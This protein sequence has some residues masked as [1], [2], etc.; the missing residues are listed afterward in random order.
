MKQTANS[1]REETENRFCFCDERPNIKYIKIYMYPDPQQV[2]KFNAQ[3]LTFY[4]C[5]HNINTPKESLPT[6]HH[7]TYH[8][9]LLFV[10]V[11]VC[12]YVC[13]GRVCMPWSADMCT[14]TFSYGECQFFF[15][16][17]LL[18]SSFIFI[19]YATHTHHSIDKV[20]YI[21]RCIAIWRLPYNIIHEQRQQQQQQQLQ[22][23]QHRR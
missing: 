10:N 4:S 2:M 6:S 13:V 8:R 9:L 23:H 22:Q 1:G 19:Y 12:T 21:N 15:F 7:I 20:Y 3:C 14:N 18:L 11:R 5:T 16:L 17:L